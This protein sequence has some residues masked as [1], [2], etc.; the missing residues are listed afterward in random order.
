MNIIPSTCKNCQAGKA[1]AERE[2]AVSKLGCQ[3]TYEL[4]DD[5]MKTHRG[6]VGDCREEWEAFRACHEAQ[7]KA[8][9]D[10]ADNK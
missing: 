4:V 1:T 8:K 5:C 3:A 9:V 6:N 7:K 2:A 10:A